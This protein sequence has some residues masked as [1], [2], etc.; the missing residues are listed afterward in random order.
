MPHLREYHRAFNEQELGKRNRQGES[1]GKGYIQAG[2]NPLT[3]DSLRAN[4]PPSENMA[5]HQM[6]P[7][8]TT[9]A[10]QLTTAIA[11]YIWKGA[12]FRLPKST[13]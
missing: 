11:C 12:T 4:T 6:L 10:R 1:P 3:T 7:A 13:V 8:P 2:L 5:Y 9:C